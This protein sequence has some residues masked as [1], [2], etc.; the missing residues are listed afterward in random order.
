MGATAA[1][2]TTVVV[3]R[4]R[5]EQLLRTLPQHRPPV[6]VV[7]NGSTDGTSAAVRER[8]PEVDVVRLGRNKGA[9]ARN[10]GVQRSGTP[11][12]AF[13]DD[14]SWW[15]VETLDVCA[16]V[17]DAHPR[18]GLVAA[19]LLVASKRAPDP[20]CQVMSASP[21]PRRIDVPGRP[22]LGFVAC[23]AVARREAFLTCAGFNRIIFFGGE[24]ELLALDLASSGWEL[25]YLP[26]VVAHHDPQMVDDRRADRQR[27][28]TRN[29]ILVALMRRPWTVVVRRVLTGL[30]TGVS[31]VKG[32]SDVIPR[33]RQAYLARSPLSSDVEARLR[34]LETWQR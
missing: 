26:D 31:G 10:M 24:E 9:V 2:V 25:T 22:V 16:D 34:L 21:L 13:A 17:L 18:L 33:I 12:V 5:R 15:R 30:A 20:I 19:R 27:L 29:S 1:R 4:N 23:A 28:L 8:F 11:Y 14:D 32:A 3:T 6:V 7:D